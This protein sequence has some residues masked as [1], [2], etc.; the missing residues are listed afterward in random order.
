MK[1]D[2]QTKLNRVLLPHKYYKLATKQPNPETRELTF[3]DFL[4]SPRLNIILNLLRKTT[5]I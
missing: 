3:G 5:P 4:S 2:E 1:R